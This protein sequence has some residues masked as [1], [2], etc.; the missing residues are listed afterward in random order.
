ML[1]Q[2]KGGSG[3]IKKEEIARLRQAERRLR[4]EWNVAQKPAT[5]LRFE[6]SLD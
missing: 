3:R 4:V 5:T 1:V 2:V 6:R